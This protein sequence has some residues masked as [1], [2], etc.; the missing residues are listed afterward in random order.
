MTELKTKV[1]SGRLKSGLFKPEQR[2]YLRRL[3]TIFVLGV[4]GL[5]RFSLG[6]GVGGDK[7]TDEDFKR[8]EENI[9]KT[10]EKDKKKKEKKEDGPND[11]SIPS[12]GRFRD[13]WEKF[14]HPGGG[15]EG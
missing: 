9:K 12:T 15:F 8:V 6:G 7:L 3:F 13:W 1:T 4:V 5:G 11:D 10:R 14:I 2:R